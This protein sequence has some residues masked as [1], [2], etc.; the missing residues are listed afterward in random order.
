MFRFVG[1]LWN[2]SDR[3]QSSVVDGLGRQL[4]QRS[5][6]WRCTFDHDGL[7]VFSTEDATGALRAHMLE[8]KAGVVL[9]SLF[10][11]NRDVLDESPPRHAQLGAEATRN[12]LQSDGRW[13]TRR[14]RGPTP[15]SR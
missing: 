4:M 2:A 12:I 3:Q 11:R 7:R 6:Q 8:N 9:G 15:D 14:G 13:L 10:E 1:F 5:A